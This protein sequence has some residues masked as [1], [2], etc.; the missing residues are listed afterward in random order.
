MFHSEG[1]DAQRQCLWKIAP[2]QQPIPLLVP[3]LCPTVLELLIHPPHRV[4]C[5]FLVSSKVSWPLFTPAHCFVLTVISKH[6]LPAGSCSACIYQI[7][8]KFSLWKITT[9]Q[10]AGCK[11]GCLLQASAT[12]CR[13]WDGLLPSICSVSWCS[14]LFISPRKCLARNET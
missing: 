3:G 12:H 2:G 11:K 4:R 5:R 9:W 8:F 7:T 1:G 10:P 14:E 13:T 6:L